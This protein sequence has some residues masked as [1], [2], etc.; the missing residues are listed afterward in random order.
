M[1][2]YFAW[3][4]FILQ[5]GVYGFTNGRE[6]LTTDQNGQLVF[7]ELLNQRWLGINPD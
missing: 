3:G 7:D 1:H 2:Y 4:F 6:Y 5:W